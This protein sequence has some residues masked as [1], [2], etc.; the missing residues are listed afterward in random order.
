MKRFATALVLTFWGLAGAFGQSLIEL[1][2]STASH[3]WVDPDRQVIL[4]AN[5][6][7]SVSFD[8]SARLAVSGDKIF[9]LASVTQN[10]QGVFLQE[11]DFQQLKAWL[12]EEKPAS[13]GFKVPLETSH[14]DLKVIVLDP[15]H[16]G[17]DPGCMATHTIDG[18][19]VT[20]EEKNLTLAVVLDLAKLLRQRYPDK[21]I[22]LTRTGDT[23]PTLAERV[24]I[25]NSQKLGKNEGIL[26]LSVHFNASINQNARGQEYWYVPPDYQRDV[27]SVRAADKMPEAAVPVMNAW[28]DSEYKQE[29][30]DLAHDLSVSVSQVLGKKE[31]ERGVKENPWY[32][33]RHTRMPAVLAEMGFLTNPEEAALL[34]NPAYLKKLA[35]GLYNGIQVFIQNFEEGP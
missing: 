18:K 28:L 14:P 11:R 21:K 19:R 26:Y 12:E 31:P 22:V 13:S 35:Y 16:G 8:P 7:A 15:G 32:V 6:R 23:Y 10:S 1:A 2:Q 29:S 20:L 5:S 27:L 30:Y 4:L 24:K 9:E 17:K 33:V 34:E 25:A 3:V